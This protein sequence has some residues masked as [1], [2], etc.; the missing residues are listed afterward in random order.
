MRSIGNVYNFTD[1]ETDV[2]Y[3][4]R[5]ATRNK[6]VRVTN[7]NINESV[8]C[9]ACNCA[10]AL[11]AKDSKDVDYVRIGAGVALIGNKDD[12][13]LTRYILDNT[14]S[15]YAK[16]FDIASL[17]KGQKVFLPGLYTL[18]APKGSKKI[19]AR[20]GRP[21]GTNVRNG[22]A[23]SVFNSKQV[24]GVFWPAPEEDV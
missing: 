3:E 5:D 19:G 1:K 16:A 22:K 4:V 14:T 20:A 6:R 10:I 2:T 21:S 18:I 13:Y 7:K 17:E 8:Q 11:G 23:R 12:S 15:W 9:D 24:R